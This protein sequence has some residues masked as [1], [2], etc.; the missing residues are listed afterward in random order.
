[1]K[2]SNPKLAKINE[3]HQDSENLVGQNGTKLTKVTRTQSNEMKQNEPKWS[4][5]ERSGPKRR[6]PVLKF[7]FSHN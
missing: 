4:E 7:S 5:V 1:M 3:I 6:D 2:Q